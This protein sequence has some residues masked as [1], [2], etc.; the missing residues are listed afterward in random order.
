MVY[1]SS[2]T[3][4]FCTV[5]AERD[6]GPLKEAH[7][8][9]L[10]IL[11]V[12]TTT[13]QGRAAL[14]GMWAH[15]EVAPG[16]RGVPT[17]V[18]NDVL[19]VGAGEI[20]EKLPG[21]IAEGVK[22]GG[23]GWSAIP[24]LEG[25]LA[26]DFSSEL[27]QV[28]PPAASPDWRARFAGDLPG[29]YVSTAL[30]ILMLLLAL[31]MLPRRAWQGELSRKATFPLKVTVASVGLAVALYLS[32]GETSQED[33]ICGPIGQCNVVQHSDLAMLFGVIPVA[34]LGALAYA[35]LLGIYLYRRW[36]TSK[37]ARLMPLA[38]FGL[39]LVGFVFSILLTF[40]QPFV[41]GATCIWCLASAV[42][43]SLSFLFSIGAGRQMLAQLRARGLSSVL[44][45][46]LN[47]QESA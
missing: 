14:Q 42:T 1:F 29:N 25:L 43:M 12:D 2:P 32:Y 7:G 45:T 39:T 35:T 6:L 40:W 18:I 10:R 4:P 34:V 9:A 37:F 20:P 5:V 8:D 24:G 38:S 19:L 17:V 11:T 3:C 22:A 41:I 31:V 15:Y 16:R 13:E 36:S 30:L 44:E 21:L 33:L 46:P 47:S 26:A 28:A 23:F 27:S